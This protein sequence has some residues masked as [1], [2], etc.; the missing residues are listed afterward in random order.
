MSR[1]TTRPR[2]LPRPCRGGDRCPPAA[3]AAAS[4]RSPRP[5]STAMSSIQEADRPGAGRVEPGA[6]ADRP[7]LAVD[8]RQFRQR[9]LLLHHA[10]P[11]AAGRLHECRRWSTSACSPSISTRTEASTHRQ[12]RHEGRQG[13]RLHLAHHADRRQGPELHRSQSCW[14]ASARFR[15]TIL[16]GGRRARPSPTPDAPSRH[17]ESADCR[18]AGTQ[19]PAG[20]APAGLLACSGLPIRQL[21]REHGEQQQRDDVGDLDRRVDGR[22]GGVLVGIADRVAG[23]RGLVRLASP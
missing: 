9:G 23:H 16:G 3:S 19:R 22:A 2:A 5:A 12:L 8:H 14:P 7:R 10:D 17:R 18:L 21:V 6:G 13:V 1:R 11:Q 4:R 15:S 20:I